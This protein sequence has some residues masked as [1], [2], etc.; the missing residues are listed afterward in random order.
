MLGWFVAG[1]CLAMLAGAALLFL[2]SVV[3]SGRIS[4]YEEAQDE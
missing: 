4:R 3:L 1:F 2:S